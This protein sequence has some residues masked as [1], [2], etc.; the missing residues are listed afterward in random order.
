MSIEEVNARE[1]FCKITFTYRFWYKTILK[2]HS[3]YAFFCIICVKREEWILYPFFAFDAT[4]HRCNV[5]IW[6]KRRCRHRRKCTRIV[7]MRLQAS[8]IRLD[9]LCTWWRLGMGLGPIFKRPN[10]FQYKRNASIAADTRCVYTLMTACERGSSGR[11]NCPCGKK[12]DWPPKY[13]CHM[14]NCAVYKSAHV[15][16]RPKI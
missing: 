1:G 10:V 11:V 9:T 8:S 4:S 12:F 2:V 5:A 15:E 7:W 3:H 13:H 16:E 14:C 6:C